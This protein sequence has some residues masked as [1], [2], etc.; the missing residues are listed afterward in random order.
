MDALSRWALRAAAAVS[1]AALL[2]TLAWVLLTFAA[3]P[4]DGS[5][6]NILFD[7]A[8][9]RAHLPLYVDPLKGAWE[10]GAPP[11]RYYVYNTPVWAW[12]LARAPEG[13]AAAA[14]RAVSSLCWFGLLAAVPIAARPEHR[15][16]AALAALFAA[17]AWVLAIYG[18]SGRADA[19][20]VA[21]AGAALLRG[22]RRGRVGA[23][24]GALFALA[25]FVKPNVL[26]LA[27]GALLAEVSLRKRAAWPAVAGALCAGAAMAALLHVTTGGQWITHILRSTYGKMDLAFWWRQASARLPFFG[28]PIAAAL[29]CAW[30]ARGDAGARIA[31][32]ALATSTTWT[33][34]QVAKAASASN[35]WME[36]LVG[37]AVTFAVAPLPELSPRARAAAGC[38][39]LV[40]A[41]WTGTASVRSAIEG[42]GETPA[43]ARALAQ[44]RGA[45][46]AK[47][48]DIVLADEPG[49]EFTLNG[50]IVQTAV[51]FAYQSRV[52]AF[53]VDLW[54]ADLTHPR[55]V[56]LVLQSDLLERALTEENAEQDLFTPPVR[57]ALVEKFSLARRDAGLYVYCRR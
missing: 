17:G 26:S 10:H 35:Y 50:R 57:A 28:L 21:L 46:A 38:A 56:G 41:L 12:L 42:I 23:L 14:S 55:V 18:A 6:G 30:R 16:A 20:A 22:A 31:G 34:F 4:L 27:A 45:C 52:G 48:D 19:L 33:L 2:A 49:L 53:P 29:A 3:R 40:Q 44:A 1:C 37:M 54:V 11:S 43:R 13:E 47:P 32:A 51:Q 9:L 39:A 15:R 8:R 24:E 7:A 25:P 5:E 36:P